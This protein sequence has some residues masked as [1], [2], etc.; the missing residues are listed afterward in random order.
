MGKQSGLMQRH[1]QEKD[2]LLEK[3]QGIVIQYMID[4]LQITMR[5]RGWGYDRI[6]A[7]T[8]DWKETRDELREAIEPN[9]KECDVKQEK[10]QR[11]FEDICANKKLQPIPFYERY[12]F[13]KRVR[14]DRKYKEKKKKWK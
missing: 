5:K 9:H 10:M 14:Y 8:M 3:G 4:T 6:M 1:E 12:P 2:D 13:L 7:L 11:W